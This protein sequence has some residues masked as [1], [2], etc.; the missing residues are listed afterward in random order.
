MPQFI[1]YEN[2]NSTKKKESPYLLDV[3]SDLLDELRTTVVIPLCPKSILGG[4]VI[5]KLCPIFT[6]DSK[7]FVAMT[8]QIAGIDRKILGKE[9]CDLSHYRSDVIAALDFIISGI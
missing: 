2:T 7:D 1:V 5:S 3:Q 9:I 6:I 8:Q 4:A